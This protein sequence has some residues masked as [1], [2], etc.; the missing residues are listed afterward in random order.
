MPEQ[1]ALRGALSFRLPHTHLPGM[2]Y[3]VLIPAWAWTLLIASL[4]IRMDFTLQAHTQT[5]RAHT[6]AQLLLIPTGLIAIISAWATTAYPL[7]S[8]SCQASTL[9]MPSLLLPG[10]SLYLF[11]ST[12]SRTLPYRFYIMFGTYLLL[13]SL[14]MARSG[15][16]CTV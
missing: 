7:N 8:F 9:I 6:L 15:A 4:W 2:L 1:S 13:T 3:I 16:L 14:S 5:P 12:K 11:F 10:L